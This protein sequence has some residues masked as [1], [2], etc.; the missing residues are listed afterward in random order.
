MTSR[1]GL[2]YNVVK[3]KQKKRKR[4]THGIPNKTKRQSATDDLGMS[5]RELIALHY[6]NYR[7]LNWALSS[8]IY[9]GGDTSMN[10]DRCEDDGFIMCG[11]K[12]ASYC[13]YFRQ[14]KQN[15]DRIKSYSYYPFQHGHCLQKTGLKHDDELIPKSD[16]IELIDKYYDKFI[17]ESDADEL[18]VEIEHMKDVGDRRW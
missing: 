11:D 14:T 6:R 4:G 8:L 9:G 1:C 18:I 13:K 16:V 3:L 2:W 10:Y 7:I 5:P 15:M 12:K 17:Y